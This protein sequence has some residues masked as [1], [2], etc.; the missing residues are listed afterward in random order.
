MREHPSPASMHRWPA[1]V[2]GDPGTA[3]GAGGGP[4]R[5]LFWLLVAPQVRR[6]P[7][8]G[9]GAWPGM[10][11]PCR[12]R[13]ARLGPRGAANSS[14]SRQERAAPPGG[15]RRAASGRRQS[16]HPAWGGP[17]APIGPPGTRTRRWQSAARQAAHGRPGGASRRPLPPAP[18]DATAR[19]LPCC[20]V[21][22][23]D[24]GRPGLPRAH[25]R[26]VQPRLQVRQR[27]AEGSMHRSGW[28]R[29]GRSAA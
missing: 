21:K 8:G 17:A 13:A 15:G 28:P 9:A 2:L 10:V 11:A 22:S 26:Y 6:G 24:A 14:A 25:A 5:P 29:H 18:A 23:K 7:G 20:R 1:C 4:A 19:S 3:H 27:S 12:R 16:M